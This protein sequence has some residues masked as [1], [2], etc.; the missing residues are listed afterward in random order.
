MDLGSDPASSAWGLALPLG[1]FVACI[2][3]AFRRPGHHHRDQRDGDPGLG[4]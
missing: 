1:L 2:V 3:A 4:G